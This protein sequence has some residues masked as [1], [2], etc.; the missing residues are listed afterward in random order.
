MSLREILTFDEWVKL[1][2]VTTPSSSG[3]GSP[4]EYQTYVREQE[5]KGNIRGVD[6]LTDREVQT[7]LLI[8]TVRN[9]KRLNNISNILTFFLVITIISIVFSLAGL[10]LLSQ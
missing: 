6:S 5:R 8:L 4:E 3:K 10:S 1:K 7:R 2:S 9:S